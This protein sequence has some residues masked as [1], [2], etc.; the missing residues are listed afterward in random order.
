MCPIDDLFT[1]KAISSIILS[2]RSKF[3]MQAKIKYND[4]NSE[5]ILIKNQKNKFID[6][7]DYIYSKIK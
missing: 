6:F 5:I 4:G 2:Y 1:K 3:Y 7:L